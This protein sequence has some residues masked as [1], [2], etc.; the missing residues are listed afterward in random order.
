MISLSLTD[1]SDALLQTSYQWFDRSGT[2]NSTA[3]ETRLVKSEAT[4]AKVKVDPRGRRFQQQVIQPLDESRPSRTASPTPDFPS[5]MSHPKVRVH[6]IQVPTHV[7]S[8]EFQNT[9]YAIAL[10]QYTKYDIY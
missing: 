3:I 1:A 7:A 5:P 10:V 4:Y 8:P 2:S 9:S 6:K